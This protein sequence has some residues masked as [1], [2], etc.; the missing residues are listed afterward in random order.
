MGRLKE[1]VLA[2][3]QALALNPGLVDARF[4]QAILVKLIAEQSPDESEP[5][6]EDIERARADAS[7]LDSTPDTSARPS[8]SQLA[9]ARGVRTDEPGPSRADSAPDDS[10]RVDTGRIE[11]QSPSIQDVSA[12]S[13]G[14]HSSENHADLT[15]GEPMRQSESGADRQWTPE[16]VEAALA[17]VPDDPGS[18]LRQRFRYE[19]E[20]RRWQQVHNTD[21]WER[22]M[23]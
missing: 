14:N 5:D 15:S 10:G 17:R 4:N 3:D 16:E 8:E 22:G 20:K 18:L 1:A 12:Q 23:T 7:T 11:A 2:Y 6:P 9:S 21:A 13:G 19:F